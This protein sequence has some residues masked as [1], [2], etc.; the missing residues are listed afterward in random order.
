MQYIYIYTLLEK[1]SVRLILQQGKTPLIIEPFPSVSFSGMMEYNAIKSCTIEETLCHR[2][3]YDNKIIE[4][5]Q[6]QYYSIIAT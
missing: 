3:E 5:F 1:V 6:Q 2:R 4:K